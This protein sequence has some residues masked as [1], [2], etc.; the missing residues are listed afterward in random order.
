MRYEIQTVD[1]TNTIRTFVCE[2]K[3]EL[4]PTY[5]FKCFDNHEPIKLKT[6]EGALVFINLK[7][8]THLSISPQIVVEAVQEATSS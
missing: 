7:E 5:F 6:I 4:D 2:Y 1:T 8:I 3:D